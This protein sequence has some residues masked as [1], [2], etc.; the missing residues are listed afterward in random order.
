[1]SA[2]RNIVETDEVVIMTFPK[3]IAFYYNMLTA[4]EQCYR[5][6]TSGVPALKFLKSEEPIMLLSQD[7]NESHGNMQKHRRMMGD[8]LDGMD[9]TRGSSLH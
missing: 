7:M 1:M 2:E 4:I 9:G 6:L 3:T 5:R 8:P